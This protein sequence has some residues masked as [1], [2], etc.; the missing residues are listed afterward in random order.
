MIQAI[1]ALLEAGASVEHKKVHV[2]KPKGAKF[3]EII[4]FDGK[5]NPYGDTYKYD[6]AE[7]A[8]EHFLSLSGLGEK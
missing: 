4:Q 3:T 2:Y 8:A 5:S 6:S 7:E 1:V